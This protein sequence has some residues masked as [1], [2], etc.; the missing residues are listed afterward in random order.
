MDIVLWSHVGGGAVAIVAGAVALASKKGRANHKQAGKLFVAGMLIMALPGG[1]L[2]ALASK[3]FDVLSS[4][5]ACYWV[6]S[7]WHAFK[8]GSR[9]RDRLLMSGGILCLVGY[10]GV[11]AFAIATGIRATDAPPGAGYVFATLLALSIYGDYRAFNQQYTR[12]QVL[13][14]HLW[15]MTAALFLATAS[16]FG[17]RPHLFPEWMQSSG[18]LLLLTFAPLIC[19]AYF[20]FRP[21]LIAR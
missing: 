16:F 14:R 5:L 10:L 17:A 19:M 6:V 3:P 20:R 9:G 11:E 21:R 7:G 18:V 15:R 12:A 1:V 13:V 4:M 2:A 8:S